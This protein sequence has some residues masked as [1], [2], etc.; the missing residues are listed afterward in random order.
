MLSPMH[1]SHPMF[2]HLTLI[3]VSLLTLAEPE[4]GSFY[5]MVPP[6]KLFWFWPRLLHTIKLDHTSLCAHVWMITIVFF[7]SHLLTF[8][9]MEPP[10]KAYNVMKKMEFP[11]EASTILI[12][13]PLFFFWKVIVFSFPCFCIIDLQDLT[14]A[15]SLYFFH[16]G[17]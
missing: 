10:W 15:T 16:M 13:F 8:Q 1:A 2:W 4:E 17:G 3:K 14:V 7:F 9:I 5:I 6:K 12:S 11:Y